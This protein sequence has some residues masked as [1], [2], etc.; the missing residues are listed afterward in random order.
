MG[1][2]RMKWMSE[3]NINVINRIVAISIVAV[4]IVLLIAPPTVSFAARN[5][6]GGTKLSLSTAKQLAVAKSERIEGL[7][8]SIEAKEAARTSALK[9]LTEKQKN[10]S[11]FRWSTLL[12]Y[13]LPTKPNE[14]ESF[15]FQYK[16]I[17]LQ[18]EIDV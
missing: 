18:S 10:M 13:K 5:N 1:R 9:S 3:N 6:R 12:S 4:F 16:P 15:E 8:L 7:E 2:R 11:S 14:Q 17:Q